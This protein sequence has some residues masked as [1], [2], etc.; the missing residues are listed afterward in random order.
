MFFI[1]YKI[2]EFF[3]M[4]N[5]NLVHLVYF[6]NNSF[7]FTVLTYNLLIYNLIVDIYILLPL[8]EIL[9]RRN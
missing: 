4:I 8:P 3:M 6:Q 2:F 9:K 5:I 7:H 1:Q